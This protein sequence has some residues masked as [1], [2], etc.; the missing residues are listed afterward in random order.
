MRVCRPRDGHT[1]L[2]RG[3]WGAR[4]ALSAVC[5]QSEGWTHPHRK[6]PSG[7]SVVTHPTGGIPGPPPPVLENL[8][9]LMYASSLS[10]SLS[11][12]PSANFVLSLSL[13]LS[14][15]ESKALRE[16]RWHI[17]LYRLRGAGRQRRR[18]HLPRLP[19]PRRRRQSTSA[20]Q[21]RRRRRPAPPLKPNPYRMNFFGPTL[22]ETC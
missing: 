18:R 2:Q 6:W 8:S 12:P 1:Q 9:D 13:S 14:R 10:L 4:S 5:L 15:W 22:R 20:K 3:G 19:R 17:S 11:L 21:R 16:Q 7:G